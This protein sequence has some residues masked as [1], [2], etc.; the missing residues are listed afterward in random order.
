M[1]CYNVIVVSLMIF[2]SS[3]LYAKSD[4]FK[5]TELEKQRTIEVNRA[6]FDAFNLPR[7]ENWVYQLAD[8]GQ[9]QPRCYLNGQESFEVGSNL[10][11]K[12]TPM[13]CIEI[14]RTTRVFWPLR[15]VEVCKRENSPHHDCIIRHL[16]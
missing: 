2:W 16:N 4:E 13:E 3:L 11:F 12:G 9:L 15:W 6:F 7:E 14:N 5:A 10:N 8:K 1:N